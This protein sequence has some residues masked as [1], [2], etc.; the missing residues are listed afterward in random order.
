MFTGII[1]EKGKIK[2]LVRSRVNTISIESG[3][4][5][6]RGESI[7]IQGICLTVTDTFKH[8]FAVQS[9]QQTQRITTL[10]DWRVG[11]HVNLERALRIGDRLGGNILLGHIDEVGKIIRIR[12]NEYCIQIRPR[13]MK[14]LVPKGSIGVDGVSLTIASVSKNIFSVY[15]IPHTLKG[16]TLGNVR[17]NSFVN[18]EFDYL[19]KLVR[20]NADY[21]R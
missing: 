14:Y 15:L 18:L 7:S 1:E 11:D 5:C 21:D 19:A 10:I 8:G 13:S 16:T 4:K 9:M 12:D 6:N 3:L 17:N 2:K 20:G